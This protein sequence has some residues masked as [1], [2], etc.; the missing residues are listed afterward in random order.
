V[1]VVHR[2]HRTD[3]S[4]PK[5]KVDPGEELEQTA[6]REVEEETGYRCALGPALG[7]WTY[8]DHKQRSKAVWYW[9][10]EAIDGDSTVN[11]EV[12]EILWLEV[13]AA[14]RRVDYET[15]RSV[16]GRFAELVAIASIP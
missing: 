13:D 12:D 15:D 3:W 14:R 2:P 1:I 7:V 8:H 11:D 16:L 4:L 5:G 6:Q 10:M 9:A